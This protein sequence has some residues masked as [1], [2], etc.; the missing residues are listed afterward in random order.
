MLKEDSIEDNSKFFYI[1]KKNKMKRNEMVAGRKYLIDGRPGK[2]IRYCS[3]KNKCYSLQ[4]L[5]SNIF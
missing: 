4:Y 5:L 2:N 1:V 3:Q